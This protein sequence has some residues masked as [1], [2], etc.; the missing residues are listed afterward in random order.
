MYSSI[1]DLPAEDRIRIHRVL[2]KVNSIRAGLAYGEG[3]LKELPKGIVG[4]EK[5][6]VLAIALSNG[7]QADV[8]AEEVILKHEGDNEID[9]NAAVEKLKTSGFLNAS[10]V[11]HN[12]GYDY[13]N[14]EEIWEHQIE[15]SD[16]DFEWFIGKFDAN[17]FEWLILND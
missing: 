3:L 17:V 16:D 15:F 4:D 9:W 11:D 12:I 13:H 2:E 7:W 1:E 8:N 5:H 14:D 10:V 6:C